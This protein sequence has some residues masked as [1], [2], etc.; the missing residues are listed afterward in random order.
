VA[1]K[2]RYDSREIGVSESAFDVRDMKVHKVE[3]QV[4]VQAARFKKK[5]GEEVLRFPSEREEFIE[6]ALRKLA[7]SASGVFINGDAGVRFTIYQLQKELR[8]LGHTFSWTQLREGLYVMRRSGLKI[9]NKATGES[10]EENFLGRLVEGGV[11]RD[12]NGG[13][14][15]PWYASF[16]KLVTKSIIDLTYRQMN[17]PR[18]MS[19]KGQLARYLYRRMVSLYTFAHMEQPYQPTLVQLLEESGRGLSWE[20]KN[21]VKA[22]NRAFQQ[23]VEQGV[24]LKVEEAK[25]VKKGKALLNIHYNLYPTRALVD[26]IITANTKQ[27][28][29]KALI[30]R[31][32]LKDIRSTLD[33]E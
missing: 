25:R 16:H 24:L 17:Y 23:L 6:D 28:E 11:R 9:T 22:V 13:T 8:S 2:Y 15:E 27:R 20:M 21:N 18:L 26:E 19:I 32:R 7:T 5:D 14:Y 1:P 10:W 31:R 30:N 33:N 4:E 29:L 3:Y 12:K